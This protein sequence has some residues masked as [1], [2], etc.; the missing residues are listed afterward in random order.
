MLLKWI[1]S[2]SL[3]CLLQ[4]SFGQSGLESRID[5][6]G[7]H[8]SIPE[9]LDALSKVTGLEIAFSD[10]FFVGT[11]PLDQS[12]KNEKV[13]KILDDV[14]LGTGVEFKSS[15]G[16]ILLFKPRNA[17]LSGYLVDA[18]S[19][20][21]LVA[22]SI[23]CA[24]LQ[25]GALANEYGFFSITLPKGEREL[26]FRYVGYT[27]R[28]V[29]F[30]LKRDVERKIALAQDLQLQVV[31][32]FPESEEHTLPRALPGQGI[33]LTPGWL[34]ASPAL[35]GIEDP[36]RAAHLLPGVEAG[37][38]GLAGLHVR[39]G[40]PGHN[41]MLLDGAP[42]FIPF[43]LLGL[44]SIYNSSTI[45]SAQLHRGTFSARYGGRIGSVLD[46][47]TR[48]GDLNQW[49]GGA[50]FNLSLVETFIEGPFRKSKGAVLASFRGAP[51][52]SFLFP[53][54]D[55]TYFKGVNGALESNYWDLNFK[56]NYLLGKKDRLYLSV[57]A[58]GDSF[59]KEEYI[60]QNGQ[61]IELENEL[62][63]SNRAMSLRWN[64]QFSNKLFANTLLT[65]SRFEYKNTTLEQIV[66]TDSTARGGLFFVDSQSK[67]TH[68][69]IQTD[70][71]Y[72]PSE[73]HQMRFGGGL[74]GP[75]FTPTF[76]FLDEDSDELT[77]LE[78]VN[79]ANLQALT[80]EEDELR[81]V[82]EGHVY[83][84]DRIQLSDKINTHLGIRATLFQN[85][86]T[87]F[88]RPEPRASITYQPKPN[89][90]FYF[91]GSRMVQYLHL[92]S[93]SDF[94][95]PN[96]IWVVSSNE[97]KPQNSWLFETGTGLQVSPRLHLGM[98]IYYKSMQNLNA[99]PDSVGLIN[100]AG[101]TTPE[102]LLTQ[103]EGKAMGAE[104]TTTYQGT[105]NKGMFSYTLAKSEREFSGI[106]LG[107]VFP[108]AF[109]RRHQFKFFFTQQ[110]GERWQL[111]IN[112]LYLSPS[113][114]LNLLNARS[115]LGFINAMIDPPGEKH[116]RRSEAYHR[117]D[118]NL[119]YTMQTGPVTHRL[120]LGLFN[121]YDQKN[122]SFYD[123]TLGTADRVAGIPLTPSVI[124][125]VKF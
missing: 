71:D 111:G 80:V 25:R 46:V 42:V 70:F 10:N 84:E 31:K 69:G 93:N 76:T 94:R 5:F 23:Y 26:E 98:D 81:E 62:E 39:G 51:S 41:L 43:H 78:T 105:Q 47:R 11:P 8:R 40:D 45:K 6:T 119:S 54:F 102:N 60:Q 82:V 125:F 1:L 68:L 72:N 123:Y 16:T 21:A 13:K 109:D 114:R 12:F 61:E 48:E 106:N 34:K 90:S 97:I 14:L 74:A 55:R 83:L 15:K 17:T 73:Y 49:H 3:C 52:N 85:D 100:L 38:D 30:S 53:V 116:E 79:V 95:F 103:G 67:N 63:W 121:V 59:G 50:S 87:Q 44:Y 88:I 2:V 108:H 122:T 9:V 36:V 96:D 7:N 64:H 118:L 19:G 112:W 104:I 124:Y 92:I 113:P 33:Q 117:L 57:F 29:N 77:Q 115:S 28:K 101:L 32:I 89:A 86:D 99:L 24:E 65:Y 107:E 22:A 91:S 37:G 120:K 27:P 58:S 18:E 110:L 35:G 4:W 20:E 66:P 56:A 75:W